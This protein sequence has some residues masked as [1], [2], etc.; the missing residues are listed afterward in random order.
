MVAECREGLSRSLLAPFAHGL[1]GKAGVSCQS[2]VAETAAGLDTWSRGNEKALRKIAGPWVAG[3]AHVRHARGHEKAPAV[4]MTAGADARG[5]GAALRFPS[6]SR[7][8]RATATPLR[9]R[10]RFPARGVQR[11]V[12]VLWPP[13]APPAG[14][15]AASVPVRHLFGNVD[16]VSSST[17]VQ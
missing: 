5:I 10:E 9:V 6:A 8:L 13:E 14:L 15:R 11:T 16:G 17:L 3:G 7:G 4:V 2:S 1:E 12:V